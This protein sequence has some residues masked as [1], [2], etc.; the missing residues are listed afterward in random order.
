MRKRAIGVGTASS[1]VKRTKC[2]SRRQK[3]DVHHRTGTRPSPLLSLRRQVAHK[4]TPTAPVQIIPTLPQRQRIGL[5]CAGA[6]DPSV[7]SGPVSA[8]PVCPGG[9]PGRTSPRPEV[10]EAATTIIWK[11]NLL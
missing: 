1:P 6:G 11:Q 9:H 10:K 2:H 3:N 7:F 4:R 5:A 8:R